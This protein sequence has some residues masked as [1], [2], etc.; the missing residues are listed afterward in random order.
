MSYSTVSAAAAGHSL[1]FMAP[2][3]TFNIAGLG[4]SVC[5]VADDDLRKRFFG[6]LNALEVANGNIF[7]FTAAEA[8]FA[9][10]VNAVRDS[11]SARVRASAVI[12]FI[13]FMGLPPFSCISNKGRPH[14]LPLFAC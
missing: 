10:G 7:A 12:R 3:K 13:L 11:A 14:G 8:A 4:S 9:Q 6:W 1:T 5:Y 2:S